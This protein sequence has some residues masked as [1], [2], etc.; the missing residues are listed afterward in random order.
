ME[1]LTEL[2]F[3]CFGM[4]F[5]FFIYEFVKIRKSINRLDGIVKHLL[6]QEKN[7]SENKL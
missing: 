3:I 1:S 4:F 2:F 7:K 5:L 6:K